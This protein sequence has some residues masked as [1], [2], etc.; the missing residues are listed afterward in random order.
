MANKSKK[1]IIAYLDGNIGEIRIHNKISFYPM[2]SNHK[3]CVLRYNFLAELKLRR[4]GSQICLWYGKLLGF[5][6]KKFV[7]AT[8]ML[9]PLSV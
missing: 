1:L 6:L 8:L 3:Y 7:V 2:E 4:F 9:L 5:L